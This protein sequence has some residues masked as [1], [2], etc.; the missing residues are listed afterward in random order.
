[1]STPGVRSQFDRQATEY[2]ASAPHSSGESLQVIARL[3]AEG[4]F[5]VALD[6]ATGPGFTAFAIAP[7]SDRVVASDISP[8]ML[9][10]ARRIAGE[11]G[12]ANAGFAFVAAEAI[13]FRDASLDLVTCR[14]APHHF[15]D[16][17]A[18]LREVARVLRPGGVYL[19]ADTTTSEDGTARAWHQDMEKRR[20]PTH[21]RNLAPSEWRSVILDA[22]L[23]IDFETTTRVD[24]AFNAWTRRSGT[25]D[26]VREK[27]RAEWSVAPREAAEEFRV[28]PVP[29][30]DFTFSW[31][32][33]VC[34]ARKPV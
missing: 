5:N 28:R 17:L 25:P 19:L 9:A 31:P 13:P 8:N 24:M 4:R 27:M 26:A 15:P 16:V 33:F 2:A 7:Y 12:I 23:R 1:M 3:A 30:G 22:G 14:T 10:E 34:R 21:I 29:G 20:D 11:R 6:I 32:A 18:T